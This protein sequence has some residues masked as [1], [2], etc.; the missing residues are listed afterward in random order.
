MIDDAVI[1]TLHGVG[2]RNAVLPAEMLCESLDLRPGETVLD[3]AS[4][5]GP[6]A[7]AAARRFCTVTATDVAPEL[8]A[9]AARRAKADG[10]ELTTEVADCQV[11]P[12]G[13]ESFDVVTSTFGAMFAP[14]Q[15]RVA[16]EL[17]R[18]CRR[19]GRIGMT[20][21]APDG[22]IGDIFRAV[23]RLRP[24]LLRAAVEWGS[25]ERLHELFGDRISSLRLQRRQLVWRF[26]TAEHALEYFRTCY[27][28][29]VT[30]FEG[31]DAATQRALSDELLAI[32]E[33]RDRSGDHTL[34]APSNYV[35]AIAVRV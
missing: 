6:M 7:L 26:P 27:G 14:D 24:P 8:L 21:W 34:V 1:A 4:G 31:L 15:Q 12:F 32:L 18:V 20:N 28:P 5:S 9:D 17:V 3:I 25:S 10:L 35:E 30:T 33:A 11:L 29:T 23:G 2:A 13:N 22:L 19:G 16:N